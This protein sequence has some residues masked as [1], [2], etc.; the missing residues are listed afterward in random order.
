MKLILS[1][2]GSTRRFPMLNGATRSTSGG[3]FSRKLGCA[4]L[5][6]PNHPKTAAALLERCASGWNFTDRRQ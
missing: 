2:N 5:P 6:V 3:R 1:P 4:A